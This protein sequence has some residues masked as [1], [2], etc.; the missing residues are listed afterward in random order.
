MSEE[1]RGDEKENKENQENK[2][3]KDNR[4]I[5]TGGDR[6]RRRSAI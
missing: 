4:R 1:Q 5:R 3:N 2:E 6:G